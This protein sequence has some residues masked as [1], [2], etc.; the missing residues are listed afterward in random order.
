MRLLI[1]PPLPPRGGFLK[2]RFAADEPHIPLC[3]FPGCSHNPG[4]PLLCGAIFSCLL[5]TGLTQ[6]TTTCRSFENVSLPARKPGY[7]TETGSATLASDALLAFRFGSSLRLRGALRARSYRLRFRLAL[8]LAMRVP[9]SV[10]IGSRR[11]ERLVCIIGDVPTGSFEL[12][13]W[14]GEQLRQFSPTLRTDGQRR[15]RKFADP[16][17]FAVTLVTFVFVDR[18]CLDPRLLSNLSILCSA[19]SE[20]NLRSA[21]RHCR[22]S[23]LLTKLA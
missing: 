8:F 22:T 15:I 2:N 23:C 9:A 12:D 6:Q 11:F 17:H 5:V 21:Q 18:H 7:L 19:Y 10:A 13:G 3:T 1:T 20:V 16:L 4:A 14:R